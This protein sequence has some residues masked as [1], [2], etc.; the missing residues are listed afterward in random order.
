MKAKVAIQAKIGG[1]SYT[2][3]PG[4]TIPPALA[5]FYAAENAIEPLVATGVLEDEKAAKAANVAP[6]KD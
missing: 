5:A 6:K 2:V 3:N 1:V 4:E